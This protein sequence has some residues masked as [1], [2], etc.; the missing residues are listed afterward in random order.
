MNG[1]AQCVHGG[2]EWKRSPQHA[3]DGVNGSARRRAPLA[4]FVHDHDRVVRRRQGGHGEPL[5]LVERDAVAPDTRTAAEVDMGEP[6]AP[7]VESL[8]LEL[9]PRTFLPDLPGHEPRNRHAGS[10]QQPHQP[11]GE[12][13]LGGCLL[14]RSTR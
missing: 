1:V 8:E 9:H 14:G 11:D 5:E 2:D 10:L 13:R 6:A 7:A 12:R 3:G 4:Q